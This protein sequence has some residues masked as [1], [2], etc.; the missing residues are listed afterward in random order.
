MWLDGLLHRVALNSTVK[1]LTQE[2]DSTLEM[3]DK[4]ENCDKHAGLLGHS[5]NDDDKA[6]LNIGEFGLCYSTFYC[7]NWY[8]GAVI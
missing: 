1:Y 3:S 4:G 5:F 8:H 7:C 6:L 2:D